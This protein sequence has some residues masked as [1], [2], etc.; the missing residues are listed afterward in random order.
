MNA[1]EKQKI[2]DCLNKYCEQI[3]SQ[4][5]AA[6]TLL[7]VSDGTISQILNGNWDN[8]AP[9]MW[10]NVAAQID[11]DPNEWV[12]VETRAFTRLKD[13]LTDAQENSLVFGVIGDA[14][15]GKT[16]TVKYY[17]ANHPNVIRLSC[18]EFWNRKKFMC[19]LLRAAGMDY[20]GAT[21]ADMMESVVTE[22]KRREKPLIILD[23]AD[24]ICDQVLY[25]FITLYNELEKRCG[26]VLCATDYLEKRI[27]SGVNRNK[28]GY[29]EINSRLGRKFIP[30]QVVNSEDVAAVCMANGVTDRADITRI[31][32]ECENDFRRVERMVHATKKKGQNAA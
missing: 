7:G 10:R 5:K 27:A 13:V 28:K 18:S 12:T 22:I 26:I 15:C 19:D 16:E 11:Y 1:N 8:I 14:G 2:A 32:D 17:A 4:K 23:E 3:G 31:I 24:K 20:N 25:F 21:I 9:E 6:K 29:K 30:L